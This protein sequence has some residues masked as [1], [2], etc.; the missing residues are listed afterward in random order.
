MTIRRGGACASLSGSRMRLPYVKVL[1][2]D[3]VKVL[4]A[5]TERKQGA[6][7]QAVKS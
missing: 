7:V 4:K 5:D 1:T 6:F 2:A 3:I